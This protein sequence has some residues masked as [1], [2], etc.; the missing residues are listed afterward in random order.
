MDNAAK[1]LVIAGGILLAIIII[2]L[3]VYIWQ[4][5]GNFL[6]QGEIEKEQEKI[7]AFN[8]E[9]ESYQRQNIRGTDVVTI[10]N[11]IRNNNY[12]NAQVEELQITWEINLK[13]DFTDDNNQVI[14]KKGKHVE[15]TSGSKI[16][17]AMDNG[18]FKRLY[19]KCDSLSYNNK[20]GRVNKIVFQQ[21]LWDEL[22]S[23]E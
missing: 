1:A 4:L 16:N 18:D 23:N 19:F 14:L 10:I 12:K 17:Q 13:Q 2:S 3:G 22:F 11:K 15:T 20:T 7:K 9:Y 8:Q 6:N 5:S 21:Y